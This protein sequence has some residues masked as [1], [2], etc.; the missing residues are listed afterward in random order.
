MI[1]KINLKNF[2]IKH[3]AIIITLAIMPIFSGCAKEA[4]YKKFAT[5]S[6]GFVNKYT[7]VFVQLNVAT[8]EIVRQLLHNLKNK[9]LD[10]KLVVTSFVNLNNFQ[11]TTSGGRLL[12]ESMINELYSRGIEVVD[13]RGQGAI[14]VNKNG[15]FHLTRNPDALRSE[16]MDTYILT[17]TYFT[18][19]DKKIIINARILDSHTGDVLST[20]QI[21]YAHNDCKIFN[22][23]KPI[24]IK[25]VLPPK[26]V[27][28]KK[29][30][31]EA[32]EDE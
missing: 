8:K 20:A 16:I 2:F 26:I 10:K 12:A 32:S 28:P 5:D 19:T 24:V 21:L 18:I 25:K 13:Y 31:I 30:Y 3:I 29:I 6:A 4:L 15:E 17:A 22:S 9:K 14:V 11:Q 27:V 1:N 7:E 23:C